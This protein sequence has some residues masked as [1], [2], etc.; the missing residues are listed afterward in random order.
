VPGDKSISHRAVLMSALASGPS[1]VRGLSDGADVRHTLAAVVALGAEVVEHD[2]AVTI[3]GGGL[4]APLDTIDVGNSGTGIRLLAGIV[5]GLPFRTHIDG[6]DSVRTRP[7]DR[8]AV[9]LRLMGARIDG[10]EGGRY[11]PLVVDGGGLRGIEY[12][13]P[14]ASAQIKSAILLAG[15]GAEGTTVVHEPAVSRRH[16]EEMLV[17]RGAGLVVDGTTTTLTP[18][19]LAPLDCTVAGDPSQAAFWLAMAAALPGSEVT[20]EGLYL[21]PAR[22]G[23]LDVLVRMGADVRLTTAAD[24]SSDA[25]VT[26]GALHATDVEPHEV[27][28]L[29]DEIPILA[30]VAALAE[31]TTRIRGAHELRVKETDRLATITAMLRALGASVVEHDDGLDV[32]GG[33]LHPGTLDSSGDHR[34]AMAGAMAALAATGPTSI[35]GFEAVATSYPGFLGDLRRCAPEA[36]VE[37]SPGR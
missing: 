21:G 33:T 10:R 6:D 24:G 2:G 30:V 3:T 19:T 28:G 25:A 8:V 7:M 23:F 4:R 37:V 34:I 15:L 12:T 32:T 18:S 5:S 36:V 20:V 13:T 9:P 27:P 31:G 29:V 14:V 22:Q 35:R 16:T 17:A 26:G 1:V 11:A